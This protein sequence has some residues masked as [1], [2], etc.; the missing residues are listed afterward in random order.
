MKTWGCLVFLCVGLTAPALYAQFEYGEVLGTVRDQSGGVITGAKITLREVDTNVERSV[1]T[2]DQ[3]NY[4]FGDPDKQVTDPNNQSS[5]QGARPFSSNGPTV[6]FGIQQG[7]VT[8]FGRG[9]SY[10]STP[11]PYYRSLLNGN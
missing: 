5:G 10:N 3:G 6:Q 9:N 2:N 4:S 11:D 1:L 7:P 8:T